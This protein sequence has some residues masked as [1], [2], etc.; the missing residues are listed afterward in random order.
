M[1]KLIIISTFVALVFVAISPATAKLPIEKLNLPDGFK[2]EIYA[3][4][5]KNARQMAMG[6]NGIVFV[7]SRSAGLVHAVID[8]NKDGTADKVIEI[9]SGLTMPSLSYNFYIRGALIKGLLN[10]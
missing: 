4:N 8:E 3:E 9:A 10:I 2:I 6:H 7:G 1:R 5:V